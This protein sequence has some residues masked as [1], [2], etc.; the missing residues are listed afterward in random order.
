MYRRG[1]RGHKSVGT[2]SADE[3][4]TKRHMPTGDTAAQQQQKGA[5]RV[6]DF[7]ERDIDGIWFPAKVMSTVFIT[8]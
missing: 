6:G 7:V 4:I 8:S 1:E 5:L 3:A 2:S